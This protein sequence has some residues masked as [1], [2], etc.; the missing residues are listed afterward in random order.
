MNYTASFKTKSQEGVQGGCSRS[1]DLTDGLCC[2]LAP[3]SPLSSRRARLQAASASSGTAFEAPE[4]HLTFAERGRQ[5]APSVARRGGSGGWSVWERARQALL[6]RAKRRRSSRH[7]RAAESS[8]FGGV[9]NLGALELMVLGALGGARGTR[10]QHE[11][12]LK[13]C[14]QGTRVA[15]PS[16]GRGAVRS[17]RF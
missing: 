6:S 11:S 8:N 15:R 16:G 14:A 7:R 2:L 5:P 10:L 9:R 13:I 17:P 3:G 1:P 12:G 4:P